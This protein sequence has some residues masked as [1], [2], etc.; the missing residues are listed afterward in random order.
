MSDLF[1]LQCM[2][3]SSLTRD[4][5]WAPCT[6][7]SLSHWTTREVPIGT[8]L[9]SYSETTKLFPSGCVIFHSHQRWGKFQSLLSLTK[10]QC[11]QSYLKLSHSS[12]WV[13]AS[14]CARKF[15]SRLN[16]DVEPLKGL[17]RSSSV[18]KKEKKRK[19][20]MINSKGRGKNLY[21]K[22]VITAHNVSHQGTRFLLP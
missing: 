10:N 21:R 19:E 11:C 20:I 5:T 13:V 8:L 7:W 3:S 15:I 6:V 1:W 16:N 2:A 14:H 22:D 12:I 4:W 18:A 9:L 17:G